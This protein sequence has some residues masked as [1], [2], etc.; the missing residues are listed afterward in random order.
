MKM[1]FAGMMDQE[2]DS[3]TTMS[4]VYAF[5]GG[6]DG[7]TKFTITTTDLKMEGESMAAMGGG[8]PDLSGIKRATIVGYF[9][10]MGRTDGVAINGMEEGDMMAASMLTLTKELYRQ[11][12]FF[13]FNFPEQAVMVGSKWATKLNFGESLTAMSMGFLSNPKG[14]VPVEMEVLGFETV[15]GMPCVKVKSFSDGKVTFEMNMPGMDASNG[16]MTMTTVVNAWFNL[17]NGM[18]VK[19]DA[20]SASVIDM[21]MMTITQKSTSTSVV[22]KA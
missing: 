15:D 22:K 11:V 13:G 14:D 12:G 18:L 6:A 4:Q 8:E 7:K 5:E 20:E 10:E 9:D 19:S 21:G 1:A 16:N 3:K 2:M 17:A